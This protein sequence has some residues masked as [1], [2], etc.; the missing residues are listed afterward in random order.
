MPVKNV[1]E[2]NQTP[3]SLAYF[4]SSWLLTWVKVL[5]YKHEICASLPFLILFYSSYFTDLIFKKS[6]D[7]SR[8]SDRLKNLVVSDL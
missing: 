6:S 1:Q 8:S 5:T 4:F 7:P 3:A 2:K